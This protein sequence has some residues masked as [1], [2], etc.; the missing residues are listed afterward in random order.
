MRI[1]FEKDGGALLDRDDKQ[2][3]VKALPRTLFIL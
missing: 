2:V 3:A 1:F